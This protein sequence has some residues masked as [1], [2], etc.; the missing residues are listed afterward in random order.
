MNNE[1]FTSEDLYLLCDAFQ[2]NGRQNQYNLVL[3]ERDQVQYCDIKK[4]Y[5]EVCQ[6]FRLVDNDAW[7][8]ECF[9]E[10]DM[11]WLVRM[12][13]QTLAC[14]VEDRIT[15]PIAMLR[16][17]YHT[18]KKIEIENLKSKIGTIW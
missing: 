13:K 18:R 7:R 6:T 8:P 1:S 11:L 10:Y 12:W 16:T 2:A 4:H 5:G 9:N 15:I 14:H 3:Y 17:K